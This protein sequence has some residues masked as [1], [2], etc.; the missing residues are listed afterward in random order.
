MKKLFLQGDWSEMV[1]EGLLRFLPKKPSYSNYGE[2]VDG[3]VDPE[4]D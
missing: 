3:E 2:V 1:G 4:P